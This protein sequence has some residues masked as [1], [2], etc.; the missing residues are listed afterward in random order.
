MI[1]V[2]AAGPLTTVQDLGRPGW[3]AFG[4]PVAGAADRQALVAANLLAGNPPGAAALE[5]TL[6]GGAFVFAEPAYAALAGADLRATLDGA[7]V[8]AWSA[9]PV[10]AGAR[11]ALGAAVA[12]V[13]AYLAVRGGVDVPP[14]LGSRSTYA[15]A[16][17]GGQEGR[18]LRPGDRLPV[19]AASSAPAGPRALG[20][21]AVPRYE[22]QLE[23]RVLLGPQ[24]DAFTARG[25]ETLL[26]ADFRVTDRSDRMG[27]R[28]DGPVIE[29]AGGADIVSDALLPGAVQVPG[30]G[31]PIV[32]G[33]DAPT[34]G[35]YAKIAT[36][37]G[38]DLARLA[39]ARPGAVVRFRRVAEAE[40][41]EALR[42]ER[43]AWARL[44]AALEG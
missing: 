22:G 26:G 2:V 44:A 1:E 25:C 8:R 17:V 21:S 15:R 5:L 32:M 6:Q 3:R 19:G 16:R 41:V 38:P 23:L 9:F 20:P 33:V 10:R 13:R 24:D 42:H 12:G 29:L 31:R 35:G 28:L 30:D 34:V 40:A 7:P 18:A 11:L 4:M 39:Q 37:I 43:E 36:V 27:W 14:V